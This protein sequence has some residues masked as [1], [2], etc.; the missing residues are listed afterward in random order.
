VTDFS[1]NARIYDRR[2]GALLSNDLTQ[3]LIAA[4]HLPADAHVLDVGAGTGRVAIPL[5]SLG[6]RIVAIDPSAAMLKQLR[7][8]SAGCCTSGAMAIRMRSGRRFAS[9]RAGCSRPRASRTRFTRAGARHRTSIA[10]WSS[11]A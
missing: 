10:R 5:A 7:E 2:H 9:R 3:R 11:A 4:A 6:R 1:A 8:K